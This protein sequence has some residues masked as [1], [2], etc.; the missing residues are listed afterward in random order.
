MRTAAEVGAKKMLSGK[1]KKKTQRERERE[2]KYYTGSTFVDFSS[3]S[4]H[5]SP[6]NTHTHTHEKGSAIIIFKKFT[7]PFFQ[8]KLSF[9]RRSI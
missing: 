4:T 8:T 6:L 5:F 3:S 1:E 2:R 7:V 9:F